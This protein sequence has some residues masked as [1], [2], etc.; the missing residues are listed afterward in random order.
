VIP[1]ESQHIEDIL[2]TAL[3][4]FTARFDSHEFTLYANEDFSQIGTSVRGA[5][6]ILGV[7]DSA[8]YKRLKQG[9]I[10]FA[11][12]SAEIP[13]AG[14]L[15]GANLIT[16][17][18]LFRL[19]VRYNEP[20][21]IAMGEAGAHVFLL[22]LAGLQVKPVVPQAPTYPQLPPHK[23]ALE[24]SDCIVG[25]HGNLGDL[26]PRLAQILIDRA[27]Q[28][29]M[30]LGLP[31][32]PEPTLAGAVEIATGLGFKVGKEQSQLGK[33]VARAWREAGNGE[34]LKAKRECGGA[35]RPISV[36][37]TNDPTVIV[38]IKTFYG[39]TIG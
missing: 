31:S 9:A 12:L 13:T 20:L 17:S 14:G 11:T 4:P 32:A 28:T 1:L 21:A 5:A 3:T 23:E 2:M 27:M 38:A 30:P 15:Q 24:V 26:D 19:A 29:V 25:I 6:E 36:Y 10:S 8:I 39:V 22:G 7:S 16:P 33:A 37:P 35:M 34:P 18:V